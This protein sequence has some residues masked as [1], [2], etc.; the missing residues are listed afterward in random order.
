LTQITREE[1]ADRAQRL[2]THG[3][4]IAPPG[5]RLVVVCTD[6]S[7]AFVG[8]GSNTSDADVMKILWC[9]IHGEDRI[10]HVEKP[11]VKP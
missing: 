3:H 8:V 4:S 6:E 2:A 1:L 9:A 11:A 5:T 10:D 7:G